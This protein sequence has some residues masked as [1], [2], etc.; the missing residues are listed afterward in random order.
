MPAM[1]EPALKMSGY[2]A[3][4]SSVIIAPD[5][6]PVEYTRSAFALYL[7]MAYVTIC[8][9]ASLSPPPERVQALFDSTSQHL[10][11]LGTTM[12]NPY[13]SAALTTP[14]PCAC[15]NTEEAVPP[16]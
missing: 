14:P 3:R 5:E 16:Q 6:S 9:M 7:P 11:L 10:P 8:L 13:W 15:P 2:S 4:R 1:A 12:M